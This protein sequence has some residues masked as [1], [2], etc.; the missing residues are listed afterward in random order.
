[1]RSA[2]LILGCFCGAAI[3]GLTVKFG[4]S[5]SDGILDGCIAASIY[6]AIA[7]G[8]LVIHVAGIRLATRHSKPAVGT[9]AVI[10]GVAILAISLTNNI[11][12]TAERLNVTKARRTQTAQSVQDD[13]RDLKRMQDERE[14]LKFDP[15][16]WSAVSAAR[17][18][19]D[20]A[21]AVKKAE[22][23]KRGPLCR[24]K[25]V[26]EE[27]ALGGAEKAGRDKAATDRAAEL[28][29]S[30]P[31]LKEKIANA[32]PVLETN[33]HGRALA[34]IFSLQGDT[35]TRQF[36][37]T[38]GGLEVITF[39]LFVLYELMAP[40]E[41][42]QKQDLAAPKP[43]RTYRKRQPA[44]E[45]GQSAKI[46]H[47]PRPDTAQIIKLAEAGK[48]HREIADILGISDKT[49]QRRL[50]EHKTEMLEQAGA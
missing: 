31:L 4:F 11:D 41:A 46:I 43:K 21:T 1:M 25:E 14:A 32:G 36:T 24:G 38:N 20:A 18:K 9:I 42:P 28:D 3:V 2:V 10:I 34:S 12:A 19:A 44:N 7:L 17:A 30:I 23:D 16:D 47:M 8:A 26:E 13:R 50:K 45:G 40:K 39:C 33:V 15:T 5:T 37:L 27:A 29:K 35:S 48:K 49:V 22:C 6:G